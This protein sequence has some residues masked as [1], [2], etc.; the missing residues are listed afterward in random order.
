M[1]FWENLFGRGYASG[2]DPGAPRFEELGRE[3]ENRHA[4]TPFGRASIL[5]PKNVNEALP[6]TMSASYGL[7]RQPFHSDCASWPKPP[8]LL[9]L[10]R[11]DDGNQ[12]VATEILVL[13][14][15]AIETS[16]ATNLK[17]VVR[18]FQSKGKIALY[19]AILQRQPEIGWRVRF[20][21][22]LMSGCVEEIEAELC[23]L[24]RIDTVT[25]QTGQ[26]LVIDNYKTLHRRGS[27]SGLGI[28]RRVHRRYWG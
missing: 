2:N 3:L 9:S 11:I 17:E 21:P 4:I 16:V 8:R 5:V 1:T 23:A 25:L 19:G 22:S 14:W 20:D 27:A 18:S 28:S 15:Q 24:G 13:N 26:W 10:Y 6:G 7:S 12:K